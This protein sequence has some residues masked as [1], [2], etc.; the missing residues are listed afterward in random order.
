MDIFAFFVDEFCFAVTGMIHVPDHPFR[1]HMLVFSNLYGVSGSLL[2][3]STPEISQEGTFFDVFFCPAGKEVICD[4]DDCQSFR[5][6]PLLA[7]E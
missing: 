1:V 4:L 5:M 7:T 2:A 6:H 3:D